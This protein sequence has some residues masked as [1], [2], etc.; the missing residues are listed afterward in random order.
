MDLTMSAARTEFEQIA[1]SA[2]KDL[3]NKTGAHLLL[4]ECAE[5]CQLVSSSA[6]ASAT[7]GSAGVAWEYLLASMACRNGSKH[8]SWDTSMQMQMQACLHGRHVRMQDGCSSI[9]SACKHAAHTHHAGLLASVCS[10]GVQP[11][12]IGIIITN[13]SLFNTTPSL[14][15]TIMNHFKMSS[16]TLNYNLAGMGCSAGEAPRCSAVALECSVVAAVL[17]FVTCC[18]C[19]LCCIRL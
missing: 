4:C 2:V 5:V 19:V 7:T 6:K 14:S 18:S 11:R 10:A 8:K 1:F 15:A 17:L 9:T 13:S 3:L 12:Q 16:K